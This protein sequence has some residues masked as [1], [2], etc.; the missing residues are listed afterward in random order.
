MI[1]SIS[2][3]QY[4]GIKRTQAS[5]STIV[6]AFDLDDTLTLKPV[7]FDN[8]GLTKDEFFDAS[9]SFGAD[10]AISDL[11]RMLYNWGDHI[12]IC[13]ARPPDRLTESWQWLVKHKIPFNVLMTSTGHQCS[14]IAKQHMLKYLRREYRMVGTLVDD[15]PYNIRGARLQRISS[16]HVCKNDEYWEAHPEYIH[17]V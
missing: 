3:Q 16:I 4:V 2:H 8:T 10:Q 17:K 15:S 6:H 7:G 13:T 5:K 14:G 9:R 11:A 12:A 1:T